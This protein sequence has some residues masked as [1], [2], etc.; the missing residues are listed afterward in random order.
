M[1]KLLQFHTSSNECDWSSSSS[2][3]KNAAITST[4][5]K[6]IVFS[7]IYVHLLLIHEELSTIGSIVL[8][9]L[10]AAPKKKCYSSKDSKRILMFKFYFWTRQGWFGS[11]F[12][13]SYLFDGAN[14]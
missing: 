3:A 11:F 6:V 4:P 9:F 8:L 2:F 14:L 1:K 13:L 10:G 7:R 5:S 12:C